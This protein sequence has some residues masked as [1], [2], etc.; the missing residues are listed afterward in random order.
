MKQIN[1]FPTDSNHEIKINGQSVTLGIS[2]EITDIEYIENSELYD[3][4][5]YVKGATESLLWYVKT[6]KNF[7]SPGYMLCGEYTDAAYVYYVS[8]RAGRV[9]VCLTD[10]LD[11]ATED[12][13]A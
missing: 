6:F 2:F 7:P 4:S 9:D 8:I 10:S 3:L 13:T 11:L 5:E 1:Q 12:I